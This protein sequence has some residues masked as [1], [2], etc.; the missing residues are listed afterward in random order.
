MLDPEFNL[1]K[2]VVLEENV[3]LAKSKIALKKDEVTYLSYNQNLSVI[4]TDSE[5]S[6][7]LF[8]G[9]AF[10]PGWYVKV[11]G[12]INKMYRANFAFRG[13]LLSPGEHIVEFIYNPLS[14]RW[15]RFISLSTSL[16]MIAIIIVFFSVRIV[17]KILTRIFK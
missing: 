12:E 10:Y 4:K 1:N 16:I 13:V 5:N 9:D 3:N 6:G 11:D 17:P 8:V 15:G 14:F 7:I 2:T